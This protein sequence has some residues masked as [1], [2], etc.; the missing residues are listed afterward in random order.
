MKIIKNR[1]IPFGSYVAMVLGP[2]IF[3]KRDYI[4]SNT[5]RHESIHWAQEKELA[6]VFFYLLYVLFFVVELLR[7]QFNHQRGAAADGRY[8]STWERAY[9]MN[10]FEREAYVHELDPEYLNTRRHFAW[11]KD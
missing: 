3:T 9:R 7:C 10:P 8:R 1:I 2:L 11:A 6:I 4:S 5:I